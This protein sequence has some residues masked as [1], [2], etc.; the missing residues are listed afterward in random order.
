MEQAIS[1]DG[2]AISY[3]RS[4]S[5][6]PIVLVHGSLMNHAIAWGAVVPLLTDRFTVFNVD[7]RGRGESGGRGDHALEREFEDVVAVLEHIG[8]PAHLVGH[9]YGG[10]CILGAALLAP[11]FTRSLTVYEAPGVP[12]MSDEMMEALE[13]LELAGAWDELATTFVRDV[14]QVPGELIG[15]LK[16]SPIWPGFC[17]EA[18][19]SM[20]DFRAMRHYAFDPGVFGSLKAPLL[21]MTGSQSPRD[22]YVTDALLLAVPT[23]TEAPLEDQQHGAILT[24]PKLFV[25]TMLSFIG[26]TGP[27]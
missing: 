7:R 4:G 15:A 9:S 21:L 11:E 2:T 3:E 16:Q 6:P 20:Y 27:N 13:A 10:H 8:E 24:A 23:A 19:A 26:A 22:T 5:G 14:L 17:G 1:A 18:Q 12:G 25:D